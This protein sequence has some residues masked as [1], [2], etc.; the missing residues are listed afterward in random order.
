MAWK[1]W[2]FTIGRQACLDRL[3][4]ALSRLGALRLPARCDQ[5]PYTSSVLRLLL[6]KDIHVTDLSRLA[7]G[8]HTP[9]MEGAQIIIPNSGADDRTTGIVIG[10]NAF[11]G[12]RVELGVAPGESLRIG[13]YTSVQ[14]NC[15]ILGEVRIERHCVLSLNIYISSGDH[16]HGIRPTWLIRDQD[17]YVASRPEHAELRSS[18][19]HIEEDCW[20][21]IGVM[22]KRGTYVGRGAVIGAHA[23]VTHD[24]PPYSIQVGVPSREIGKRVRFHPPRDLDALNEQHWPYFYAGFSLRQAEVAVSRERGVLLAGS[25]VRLVLEGGP[26][27]AI[28]FRGRLN[29]GVSRLDLQSF[30]NQVPL[31]SVCITREHFDETIRVPPDA[32]D[33]MEGSHRS[34]VLKGHNE[35]ELR[36]GDPGISYGLSNV[37][38]GPKAG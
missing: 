2:R 13:D 15:V 35:I 32:L 16:H 7:L 28:R 26:I 36:S 31:G 17:E 9:I 1:V 37:S 38:L 10:D 24:V 12:R 3:L 20:V 6:R 4:L 19:V 5:K 11:I 29:P 22:I 34:A 27:D 8:S 25:T 23:V 21:G 33:R 14:D 30:C 18:P